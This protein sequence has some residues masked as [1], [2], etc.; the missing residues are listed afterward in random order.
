MF[1][2]RVFKKSFIELKKEW[3]FQ[4]RGN[5]RIYT[6]E[7]ILE[8]LRKK[9]KEKGRV[10]S[11]REIILDDELPSITT[12]YRIFNTTSLKDIYSVINIEKRGI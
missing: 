11:I 1:F 10:L 9:T 2:K 5:N 8:L 6:Q 12:I 4:A 7:M 3:G